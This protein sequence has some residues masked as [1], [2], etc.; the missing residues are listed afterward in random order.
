MGISNAL[1]Y[2]G[3][4]V[5]LVWVVPPAVVG[6]AVVVPGVVVPDVVLEP[7]SGAGTAVSPAAA[8]APD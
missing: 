1:V 6:G 2:W 4:L 8:G 3:V 5:L 7:A